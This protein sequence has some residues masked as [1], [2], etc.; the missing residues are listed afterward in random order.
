MQYYDVLTINNDN[1]IVKFIGD[2]DKL[3][4]HLKKHMAWN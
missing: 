2:A 4:R 3:K 1:D